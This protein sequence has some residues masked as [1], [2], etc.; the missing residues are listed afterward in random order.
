MKEDDQKQM[1]GEKKRERKQ[2][3][4]QEVDDGKDGGRK[5]EKGVKKEN[6]KN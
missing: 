5:E 2:R 6:E 4:E 3:Q 1:E